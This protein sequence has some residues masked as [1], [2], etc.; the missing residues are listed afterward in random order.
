MLIAALLIAAA[1][2]IGANMIVSAGKSAVERV[3]ASIDEL[4]AAK[5]SDQEDRI[6]DI[7]S[8]LDQLDSGEG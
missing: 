7:E 6:S 3:L 5:V 4:H 2:I 8:R 1:I